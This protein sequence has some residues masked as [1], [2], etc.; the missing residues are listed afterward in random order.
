[1]IWSGY[2]K[3]FIGYAL[4]LSLWG[5]AP[6]GCASAVMSRPV[7][8]EKVLDQL[9]ARGLQGMRGLMT[10]NGGRLLKGQRRVVILVKRPDQIRGEILSEFGN[11]LQQF[12]VQGGRL[13]LG[14]P[15]ENRYES[16][17]ATREGMRESLSLPLVPEEVVSLLLG[18]PPS[19]SE[20]H[21]KIWWEEIHG[22][23]VPKRIKSAHYR[24]DYSDYQDVKGFL[25]PQKVELF[26][27]AGRIDFVFQEVELNPTFQ[28]DSF[29]LKV[30]KN[31]P[32]NAIGEKDATPFP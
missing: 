15:E 31:V 12:A 16:V 2:R 25:F 26:L 10:V 23:F 18:F 28:K 1:M 21:Q 20:D 32:K 30:P 17:P 24:V 11:P 7:S 29:E 13:S 8:V 22:Q 9:R 19:H 4:L 5:F 6:L 27:G 14:W 3:R